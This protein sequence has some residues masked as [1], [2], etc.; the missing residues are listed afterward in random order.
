[1]QGFAI[2]VDGLF[3]AELEDPQPFF[4]VDGGSPLNLNGSIVLC[5]RSD[6]AI[7]RF[8][9]GNIAQFAVF[10]QPL[11]PQSVRPLKNTLVC[12]QLIESCVS[13]SWTW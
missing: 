3:M 7:D 2:Y 5:G 8:F 6:Q 9:N 1:M 13:P 11:T 4:R 12:L 10:D